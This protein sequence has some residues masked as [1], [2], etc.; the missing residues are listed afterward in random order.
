VVFAFLTNTQMVTIT[1]R[2][3]YYFLV[4]IYDKVKAVLNHNFWPFSF[5]IKKFNFFKN[6]DLGFRVLRPLKQKLF[7]TIFPLTT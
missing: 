5:T 6:F 4:K 1:E 2:G 3:I 7:E